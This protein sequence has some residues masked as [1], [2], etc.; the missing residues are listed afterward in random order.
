M[1]LHRTPYSQWSLHHIAD[2]VVVLVLLLSIILLNA[3]VEP[4]CREFQWSDASIAH[5]PHDDTVP[6]FLLLVLQF[7]VLGFFV[8]FYMWGVAACRHCIPPY[9]RIFTYSLSWWRQD[10]TVIGSDGSVVTAVSRDYTTTTGPL[11]S[12]LALLIWSAILTTFTTDLLKLYAG[13]LRPDFLSRLEALGYA[14][15]DASLPDPMANPGYYCKLNSKHSTLR[16]GRLSFPSG[17]SST[18]FSLCTT[19]CLFLF[20]HLRPFA[21]RGSLLRLLIALL[22]STF[23]FFCAVSRTRDY[24]HHFSDVMAGSLLGIGCTMLV[25]NLCFRIADGP[26]S[27]VLERSDADVE[28][29]KQYRYWAAANGGGQH[30]RASAGHAAA[31]STAATAA[32]GEGGYGAANQDGTRSNASMQFSASSRGE[33]TGTTIVTVQGPPSPTGSRS[34]LQQQQLPFITEVEFNQSTQAVPWI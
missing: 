6:V 29:M 27:V 11:Y 4:H 5:T 25:Y 34:Q 3:F 18:S 20:A 26:G 14:S 7:C 31:P 15:T 28:A 2:W 17:H 8:F 23:A 1:H 13:R 21:Y 16:E 19:M 32:P 24:K 9:G 12:W 22:P 30:D 33:D 10:S